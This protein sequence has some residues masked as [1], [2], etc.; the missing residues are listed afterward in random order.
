MK[1]VQDVMPPVVARSPTMI[2][3]DLL[4]RVLSAALASGG[5]FAEVYAEDIELFGYTY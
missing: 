2:E 5:D 4:E 3:S 1:V